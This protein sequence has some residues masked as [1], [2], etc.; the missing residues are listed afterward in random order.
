M[1]QVAESLEGA[2]ASVEK[3]IRWRGKKSQGEKW[4]LFFLL[5]PFGGYFPLILGKMWST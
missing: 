5:G 1:T 2:E 3:N 4:F